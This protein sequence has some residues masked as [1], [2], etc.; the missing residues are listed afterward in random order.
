M[1][2]DLT[3]RL[4]SLRSE[5]AV[6]ETILELFTMLFAPERLAYIGLREGK[7]EAGLTRLQGLENPP[8]LPSDL[9]SA[10]AGYSLAGLANGFALRV[11]SA[12]EPVGVVHV[13]H[14]AF[15]Q[16]QRHYVVVALSVASVCSL[17]IHNARLYERLAG[18]IRQLEQALAE[19][20]T[21]RGLLP[22]CSHCK[23]I[24]DDRGVWNVME[25]YIQKH[26]D[27]RFSH[28]LCPD[29]IGIYFPGMSPK[30]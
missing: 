1:A 12:V 30:E 8:E 27:A 23:K 19:V 25:G 9:L 16:H 18:N 26:S 14:L 4:T 17:A 3:A 29:C 15:P 13:D 11:G 22:I 10:P 2:S 6:I 21:L 28:G 24:R 5:A 20:R 7:P